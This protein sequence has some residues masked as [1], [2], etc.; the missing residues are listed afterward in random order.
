MELYGRSPERLVVF[1]KAFQELW[2]KL[3]G[4]SMAT[5]AAINVRIHRNTQTIRWSSVTKL[6]A[7]LKR[8]NVAF[9]RG[10]RPVPPPPAGRLS[11]WWLR[12]GD[13]V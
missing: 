12:D 2:L 6:T 8:E 11:C 13:V 4:S 3:Y 7:F 1:W 9:S 5:V 10:L